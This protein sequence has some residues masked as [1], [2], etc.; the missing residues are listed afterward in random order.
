MNTAHNCM[1]RDGTPQ[2]ALVHRRGA[3]D[4]KGVVFDH[5]QGRAHVLQALHTPNVRRRSGAADRGARCQ[6][7]AIDDG[8]V[9][10]FVR[11][12]SHVVVGRKHCCDGHVR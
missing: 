12:G 11:E 5:E 1:S 10:E 3:R 4:S 2:H 7:Q 6:T 8:S 9:V